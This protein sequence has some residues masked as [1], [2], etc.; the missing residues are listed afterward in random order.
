LKLEKGGTVLRVNGN[1]TI[2]NPSEEYEQIYEHFARLLKKGKSD[3]T[4][5]PLRLVADAFLLGARENVDDF[6]W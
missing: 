3:V 1:V 4:D 2:E 6:H 5:A